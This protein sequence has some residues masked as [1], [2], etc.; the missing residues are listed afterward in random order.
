MADDSESNSYGSGTES[1]QD[2]KVD[3]K[4]S[5]LLHRVFLLSSP[6]LY[7]SHYLIGLSLALYEN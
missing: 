7:L 6:H 2:A 4:V 3:A 5:L 1:D